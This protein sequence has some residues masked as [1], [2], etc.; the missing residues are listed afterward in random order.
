MASPVNDAYSAKPVGGTEQFVF[1]LDGGGDAG[2]SQPCHELLVR[3]LLGVCFLAARSL[4]SAGG[5]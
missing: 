3:A 1:A 4:L 5:P 2:V